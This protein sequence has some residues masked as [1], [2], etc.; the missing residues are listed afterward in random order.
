MTAAI[1]RNMHF[2]KEIAL[3]PFWI[4]RAGQNAMPFSAQIFELT[5]SFE[6][7]FWVKVYLGHKVL[8][9]YLVLLHN[10]GQMINSTSWKKL[11]CAVNLKQQIKERNQGKIINEKQKIKYR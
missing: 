4:E 10:Y 5:Y 6:N 9:G 8:E 11:K 7:I 3:N 2:S 1:Y